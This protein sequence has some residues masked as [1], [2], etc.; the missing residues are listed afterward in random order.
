MRYF[1]K[2][3]N[4]LFCPT[5]NIDRL[6]SLAPQEVKDNALLI[7]FTHI[8]YFWVLG[9]GLLPTVVKVKLISKN[10]EKNSK[11]VGGAVVLNA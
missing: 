8:M 4:K 6:W 11:K 10:V 2:V 1:Y 9:K 5:V 7:D 3:I